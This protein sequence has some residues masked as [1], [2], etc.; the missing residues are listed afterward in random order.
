[1]QCCV[2]EVLFD[3]VFFVAVGEVGDCD[4][5]LVEFVD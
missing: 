4:V 1:M 3:L 5:G 2:W